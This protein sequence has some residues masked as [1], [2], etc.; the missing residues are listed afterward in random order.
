MGADMTV[1]DADRITAQLKE[2]CDPR[3]HDLVDA[4]GEVLRSMADAVE[5]IQSEAEPERPAPTPT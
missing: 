5:A 4:I 3:G 1:A 2:F